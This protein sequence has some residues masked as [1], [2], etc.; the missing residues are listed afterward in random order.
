MDSLLLHGPWM[1]VVKSSLKVMTRHW[2]LSLPR[3]THTCRTAMASVGTDAPMRPPHCSS[4]GNNN[5]KRRDMPQLRHG[6]SN[7]YLLWAILHLLSNKFHLLLIL[8]LPLPL[9]RVPAAPPKITG[10]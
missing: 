7:L 5:M 6:S 1:T 3:H 8:S 9:S 4:N 2:A 10:N